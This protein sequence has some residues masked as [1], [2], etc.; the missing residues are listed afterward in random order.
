MAAGRG[1][2]RGRGW[3]SPPDLTVVADRPFL[4]AIIHNETK[5]PLFV[6]RLVNPAG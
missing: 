3:R 5:A 2:A 1:G 6:G 4:W